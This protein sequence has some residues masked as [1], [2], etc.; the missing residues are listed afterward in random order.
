MGLNSK[1]RRDKWRLIPK[2][3][4]MENDQEETSRGAGFLLTAGQ[5]DQTS[6]VGGCPINWLSRLLAKSGLCKEGLGSPRR[7]F[8]REEGSEEPDQSWAGHSLYPQPLERHCG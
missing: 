8:S 3:Q 2:E 5:H 6:R 7:R 4:R 1:S